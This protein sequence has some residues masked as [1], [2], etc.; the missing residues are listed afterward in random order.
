MPFCTSALQ[1]PDLRPP[2]LHESPSAGGTEY[3]S[4]VVTVLYVC[5]T[6]RIL[7]DVSLQTLGSVC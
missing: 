1:K 6:A 4:A 2:G 7:F 5:G 3:F